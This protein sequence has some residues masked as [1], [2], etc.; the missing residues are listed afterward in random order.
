[1]G[2]DHQTRPSRGVRDVS[3]L[4]S[5]SAVMSQRRNRQ[6]GAKAAST[7][8]FDHPVETSSEN[9]IDRLP[10]K[11]ISSMPKLASGTPFAFVIDS[12]LVR[13]ADYG[14]CHRDR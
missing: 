3:V 14:V 12:F 2:V 11:A 9:L 6:L 5:I 10:R 7:R 1:M 4:P 13:A 8:P